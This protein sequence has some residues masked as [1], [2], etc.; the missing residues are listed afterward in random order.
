MKKIFTYFSKYKK[1]GVLAPLLKLSE[2]LLE[3]FIP[4]LVAD[5]IDRGVGGGN[6]TVI[7]TD[8]LIM[9]L[10]GALGLAFSITGQYFSA[11]AAVSSS[12]PVVH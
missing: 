2:A 7:I 12:I 6:K 10:L 11:K 3:L 8:T 4:I 9:V 5:I 1:E